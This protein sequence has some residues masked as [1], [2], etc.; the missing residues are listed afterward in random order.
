MRYQNIAKFDLFRV[1]SNRLTEAIRA[2]Y[3]RQQLAQTPS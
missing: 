2:V 3:E 1:P